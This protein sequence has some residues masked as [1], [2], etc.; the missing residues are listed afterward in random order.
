M[1]RGL[2]GEGHLPDST[3]PAAPRLARSDD[4]QAWH[5]MNPL[6]AH[7]MR[8]RR[9]LDLVADSGLRADVLFRDSHTDLGDGETV[10]HEYELPARIDPARLEILEI[11]ARPPAP[12][13]RVRARSG[14]RAP[15]GRPHAFE[16]AAG[17]GRGAHRPR[18][19]YP[20]PERHAALARERGGAGPARREPGREPARGQRGGVSG[21]AAKPVPCELYAPAAHA[22]GD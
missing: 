12:M 14:E 7:G 20:P 10:V 16:P 1:M 19:V 8:R 3:G 9:R 18:D 4:P 15:S 22:D 17:R 13:A 11:D 6:P 2:E 21:P 5:R